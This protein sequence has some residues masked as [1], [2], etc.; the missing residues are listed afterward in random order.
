MSEHIEGWWFSAGKTLPNDDGRRIKVG[1]THHVEGKIVPC[2]NGLHAS[3]RPL[4]AL[5]YAPGP[6]VWRVRLSGTIV[7]HNG[8][9]HAA[10][11]RAYLAGGV[12]A[13][14]ALRKFARLCARDVL[15]LWDAQDVVTRYLRTGDETIRVVARDAAR[16][17][18]LAAGDAQNRRL[19]RMLRELVKSH[20]T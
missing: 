11:E 20:T 6:I 17:A 9:K 1:V 19:A 8:D 15:H 14:D 13:T 16:A 2:A 12:D 10:S 3:V 18:A 7:E 4:D 5:K